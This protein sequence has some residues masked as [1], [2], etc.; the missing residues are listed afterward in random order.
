MSICI[1]AEAGVNHNGSLELAKEMARVAKEAG[2]DIVKYQTAVPELVVSKFAPKAEYQKTTTDAAESQLDM[3]R[4]LHFDFDAHRELIKAQI[5]GLAEGVV[6][7]RQVGE[8]SFGIRNQRKRAERGRAPHADVGRP[9]VAVHVVVDLCGQIAARRSVL[10]VASGVQPAKRTED[11]H[12]A[13]LLLAEDRHAEEIRLGLSLVA[14]VGRM[15]RRIAVGICVGVDDAEKCVALFDVGSK[16]DGINVVVPTHHAADGSIRLRGR[17]LQVKPDAAAVFASAAHV[18]DSTF[19]D[20]FAHK[21]RDV[22]K[23]R[24]RAAQNP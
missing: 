24:G 6:V 16:V 22:D 3:I 23:R 1:I 14:R 8:F 19:I 18:F 10:H 5:V 2:A 12:G 7:G 9:H 17:A 20:A 15:K 11:A 4:R 21:L 13:E